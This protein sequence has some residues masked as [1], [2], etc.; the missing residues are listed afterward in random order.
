VE[1][2][3]KKTW[4]G[5]KAPCANYAKKVGTVKK[6]ANLRRLM[7]VNKGATLERMATKRVRQ[8]FHFARTALRGG[9]PLEIQLQ[10]WVIH[11]LPSC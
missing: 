2:T 7:H 1:S 5:T 3:V 11:K 8:T 9:F 4:E 6:L 10:N